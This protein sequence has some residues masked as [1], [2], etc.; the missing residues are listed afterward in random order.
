MDGINIL[1]SMVMCAIE[2][3]ILIPSIFIYFQSLKS[4]ILTF[5][6]KPISS[7]MSI[8]INRQAGQKRESVIDSLY[9]FN[10]WLIACNSVLG[11]A[12]ASAD[13]SFRAGGICSIGA[14]VCRVVRNHEI[15]ITAGR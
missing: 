8:G 9:G 14:F 6:Y 13:G 2:L 10:H 4:S 7:F 3:R 11:F 1:N 12:G 5:Y 15:I